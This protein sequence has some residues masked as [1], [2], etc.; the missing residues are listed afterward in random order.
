MEARGEWVAVEQWVGWVDG[1]GGGVDERTQLR[2]DKS[3][4]LGVTVG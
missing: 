4:E 1:G 2:R 3:G